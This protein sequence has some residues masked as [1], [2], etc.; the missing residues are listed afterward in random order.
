MVLLSSVRYGVLLFSVLALG[1][2]VGLLTGIHRIIHL[3]SSFSESTV[4]QPH[5]VIKIEEAQSMPDAAQPP[6]V[7]AVSHT[8]PFP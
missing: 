7:S 1:F 4:D 2:S 3:A 5:E 6:A 8:K